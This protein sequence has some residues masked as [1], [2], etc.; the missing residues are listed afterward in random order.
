M[1]ARDPAKNKRGRVDSWASRWLHTPCKIRVPSSS[2]SNLEYFRVSAEEQYYHKALHILETRP[3]GATGVHMVGFSYPY[4]GLYWVDCNRWGR[5]QADGSRM[6]CRKD[7][8]LHCWHNVEFFDVPIGERDNL[9]VHR[10][11]WSS[12]YEVSRWLGVPTPPVVAYFGSAAF[13]MEHR[14]C[15][16]RMVAS[17]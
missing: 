7:Q 2:F 3:N 1:E 5:F 15:F 11:V 16:W 17:E 6:R 8:Y 4:C 10:P 14:E 9:Y 13:S 12:D